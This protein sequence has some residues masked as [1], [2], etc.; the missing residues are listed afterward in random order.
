MAGLMAVMMLCAQVSAATP[1]VAPR[2]L[3]PEDIFALQ[4]ATD[5]QIRNDGKVAAYVRNSNDIRSDEEVHAVWMADIATGKETRIESRPG[6]STAPR[7]S[8]DG[9][10]LA[11][12]YLAPGSKKGQIY[13]YSMKTGETTAITAVAQAPRDI[14]WSPDGHSIAFIMLVPEAPLVLGAP[15]AKPNGAS[16]AD[17][18]IVIDSVNYHAD[19]R[20]Y[21]QRGHSHVFVVSA[22]GGSARQVTV[23]PYDEGGP[24]SWTPDGASL[25]VASNRE[26]DSARD[27][28]DATGSH[29]RHRNIYRVAVADGTFTAITRRV[30]SVQDPTTSPDGRSIAY[31]GFDDKH[32]GYQEYHL[33]LVDAASG[34]TRSIGDSLG[35]SIDAYRWAADGRGFFIAYAQ[36]G[37]TKLARLSLNGKLEPITE[38][39]SGG[40]LDLP[41]SGGEFSAAANGLVVYTGKA[42][43]EP[44][45]LYLAGQGKSRK[46]THLNDELF[47]RVQLGTLA[48]LPASSSF[49]HRNIGAWELQPPNFDSHKKYPLILEIH[50]GPYASYGPVFSFED[51]LFAAAGYIVVYANP[52]G[53]TSYGEEF[54]NLIQYDYPD[55]D[56]DDLMSVVDAAIDRGAVDTNNL[57]VTGGSGGGILT[58][59]TVG[60]TH[61]F[62][63]ASSQAPVV[64][65][66][67]WVVTSDVYA[68]VE[69]TWFK[70]SP[71]DDHETYWRQSP[72][73]RVDKVTTPT[74]M[75]VGD[76][77]LRTTF[78][79]AEAFYQAL[80][81]THTPTSLV[82]V[83]GAGH[84]VDRP[85]QYAAE[86]NAI[87]AWFDRYKQV[88][89]P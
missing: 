38:D 16:W 54:A 74:L 29:A 44:P 52:R 84:G 69:R 50:G 24:L 78:A 65:W 1:A 15:R 25:L 56:Y 51:E 57:F 27:P 89:S 64:D 9:E 18:L 75:I 43:H 85:S 40:E 66:A 41:Y 76:Q 55:H 77:D 21:L 32:L 67:S 20:G 58:A 35:E 12:V 80:Q 13:T 33:M 48:A 23:G 10:R 46:L 14:A 5:P 82:V 30:G 87:L 88:V 60:S 73:S 17:P 71:W 26:S 6:Q 19:G 42:S 36:G 45:E 63:A 83:P 2:V 81:L 49:D 28:I 34:D 61:R 79:Q 37:A 39:L 68:Y 11:Y 8:P 53:S 86:I 59:W 70:K 3:E 72:L 4:W 31:L 7:W 62:R 47:A 22:Q